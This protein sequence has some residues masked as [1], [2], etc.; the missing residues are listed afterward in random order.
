MSLSIYIRWCIAYRQYL[1][2]T[3]SHYQS[4][5]SNNA[6]DISPDVE[7]PLRPLRRRRISRL[8]S[9]NASPSKANVVEVRN[10]SPSP[11]NAA[12]MVETLDRRLEKIAAPRCFVVGDP[13]WSSKQELRRRRRTNTS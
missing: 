3:Q 1:Q 9:S 6:V 2:Q 11:L 10:D 12:V 8:R 7:T 13:G 5:T 4:R